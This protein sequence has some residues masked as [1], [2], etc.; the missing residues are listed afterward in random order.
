MAS[1]GDPG[2]PISSPDTVHSL[3][4][5]RRRRWLLEH[6]TSRSDD[7]ATLDELCEH[8]VAA[9]VEMSEDYVPSSDH[10]EE[11][12]TSLVHIHLPKLS[13]VGVLEYDD[14]S[15]TVRYYGDERL[16]THLVRIDE[17]R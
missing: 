13:A 17:R 6:L 12:E 8:L 15:E 14:R 2:D 4:S 1:E 3:L 5:N 10:R 16:E 11:I 7:V 9:E